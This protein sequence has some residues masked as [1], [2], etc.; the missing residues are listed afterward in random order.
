MLIVTD[1]LLFR[2]FS[3][4]LRLWTVAWGI[5]SRNWIIGF[6]QSSNLLLSI[7]GDDSDVRSLS[8]RFEGCI[9][10]DDG[11]RWTPAGFDNLRTVSNESEE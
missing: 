8:G 7:N 2:F 10:G 6:G 4:S 5:F 9:D 1:W 3:P 11:D